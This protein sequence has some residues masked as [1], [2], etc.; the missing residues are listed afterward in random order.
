MT[1][2][3]PSLIALVAAAAFAIPAYAQDELGEQ[4]RL[5]SRVWELGPE[6]K[7]VELV[8]RRLGEAFQ[9][10][11]KKLT[12]DL[13]I[14]DPLEGM[15]VDEVSKKRYAAAKEARILALE[16]LGAPELIVKH[17]RMTQEIWDELRA[18]GMESDLDKDLDKYVEQE[19]WAYEEANR[20]LGD[21]K[22]VEEAWAKWWEILLDIL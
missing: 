1:K 13:D 3:N 16:E 9:R 11:L 7:Q 15:T 18:E 12:Q 8:Q 6:S 17:A 20:R 2:R 5:H 21:P 19:I 4:E 10:Q 14:D 22:A